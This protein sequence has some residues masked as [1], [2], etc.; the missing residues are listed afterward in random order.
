MI[1]VN[2]ATKVANKMS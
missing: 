2:M 1:Y